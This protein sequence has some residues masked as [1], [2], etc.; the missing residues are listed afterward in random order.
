VE[1]LITTTPEFQGRSFGTN[2]LEAALLT[3]L[4][5]KWED[6][7]PD[8]YLSLIRK[9]DLKPRIEVLNGRKPAMSPEPAR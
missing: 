6:V 8:D 5:K 7:V 2:V 1:I 9:L 4:G 3:L